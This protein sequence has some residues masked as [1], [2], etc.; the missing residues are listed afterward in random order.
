MSL[1]EIRRDHIPDVIQVCEYSCSI[2]KMSLCRLKCRFSAT[3]IGEI[4]WA[5]M[6]AWTSRY[7]MA[8]K[9]IC[10]TPSPLWLF[11]WRKYVLSFWNATNRVRKSEPHWFC[12]YVFGC[13]NACMYVSKFWPY[14]KFWNL[15]RHKNVVKIFENFKI[16]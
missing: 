10:C 15:K 6:R 11:K 9:Q 16:F 3:S 12:L 14:A 13:S 4:Q 7:C 1:P 2:P 8:K 5:W